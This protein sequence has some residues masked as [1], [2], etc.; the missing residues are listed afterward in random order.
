MSE[1]LQP[2]LAP[3]GGPIVAATGFGGSI[4]GRHPPLSSSEERADDPAPDP[5]LLDG[6]LMFLSWF[7][8]EGTHAVHCTA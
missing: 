7:F 3:L 4:D 2:L 5:T 1:V 6:S 8:L